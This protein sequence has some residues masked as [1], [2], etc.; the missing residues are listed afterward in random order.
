MSLSIDKL[1]RKKA[2]QEP[3]KAP[4]RRK[5]KRRGRHYIS[6][7]Y[8]AQKC[9][10]P[11]KYRSSWELIVSKH[12]DADPTVLKFEYETLKIPYVFNIKTRKIRNYYPDFIVYYVDGR[13]VIIEVKRNS[14]LNNVLVMRKASAAREWAS[15]NGMS[16][17]FW[18]ES[19]IKPLMKIYQ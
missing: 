18:T 17:V 11:V 7:L 6:G 3:V 15:K 10:V 4:K 8:Q 12:L 19:I 2:T 16:Y 5:R 14:A 9:L 1:M 13:K